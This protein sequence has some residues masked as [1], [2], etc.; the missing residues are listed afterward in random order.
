MVPDECWFWFAS[1][2][3]CPSKPLPCSE[4]CCIHTQVEDQWQ[5]AIVNDFFRDVDD[6]GDAFL[7]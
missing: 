3:A 1:R 6:L 7:E 4:S 2:V 5:V